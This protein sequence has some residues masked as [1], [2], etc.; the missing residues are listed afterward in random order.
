MPNL[1]SRLPSLCTSSAPLT[2]SDVSYYNTIGQMGVSTPKL[3]FFVA[4][5]TSS[6]GSLGRY[7]WGTDSQS[8]PVSATDVPEH[9]THGSCLWSLLCSGRTRL[10]GLSSAVPKHSHTPPTPIAL[11]SKEDCLSLNIYSPIAIGGCP[12]DAAPKFLVMFYSKSMLSL[13]SF[14]RRCSLVHGGGLT[15]GNSEQFSYNVRT[16]GSVWELNFKHT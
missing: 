14:S 10:L 6:H 7:V 3:V 11:Q 2:R 13:F 12:L 16:D 9:C 8:R 5:V 1:S 4:F 15:T